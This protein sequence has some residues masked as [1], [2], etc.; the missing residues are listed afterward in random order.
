LVQI[1]CLLR[2]WTHLRQ[3]QDIFEVRGINRK[4]GAIFVARPDWFVAD[5]LALDEHDGLAELF[6]S[7]LLDCCG[8]SPLDRSQ[9][10][11]TTRIN[12]NPKISDTHNETC[13]DHQSQ[14][15]DLLHRS[16]S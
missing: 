15:S 16:H 1:Y 11:Q 5:V 3:R 2:Y 9:S 7:F 4:A 10:D 12:M 14:K 13:N 6:A 8:A